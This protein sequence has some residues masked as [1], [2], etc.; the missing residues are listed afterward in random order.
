M[1]SGGSHI[2]KECPETNNRETSIPHC[3][4]CQLKDGERPHAS[5][6]RGCSHAKEE[7]ERKRMQRPSNRGLRA[8]KFSADYVVPGKSFAAALRSNPQQRQPPVVTKEAPAPTEH[9]QQNAGQPVQA[10]NVSSV[11]LDNKFRIATV[12]Q[13]IMTEFSG[14]VSEEEKIVAITKIYFQS[15]ESKWPLEFIGPSKS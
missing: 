12:V 15:N 14:A 9:Q 7:L 13:Q 11:A 2:H 5:N 8:G 10:S 6:Y 3:C 1:W 4:N